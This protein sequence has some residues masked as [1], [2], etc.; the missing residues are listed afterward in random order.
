MDWEKLGSLTVNFLVE[1]AISSGI[2]LGFFCCFLIAALL[3]QLVTLSLRRRWYEVLGERSWIM[4][5]APGTVIHETGHA[6]F[7]LLFRHRILEMKLFAP[8]PE[9]TMGMVS[10]SWDPKS[11]Y[12]RA[13]NFFIGTGPIITGVSAIVL[14]TYFLM[15]EIWEQLDSHEFYTLSDLGAAFAALICRMIRTFCSAEIWSKWQT[16][17]WLISTLLIGSHVT[18]SREDLKNAV[19][20]IW[21]IPVSVLLFNFAVIWYRNPGELLLE[22]GSGHLVC[23]L[24]ILFFIILIL[25]TFDLLLHLP[26]FQRGTPE[27]KSARRRNAGR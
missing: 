25:G 8:T 16:W 14:L 20:G 12:Q 5:A 10:H 23:T 18:L 22:H 26:V 27:K 19:S 4:L 21:L 3:L 9:G 13:G 7:C 11:F 1:A 15:P 6:F 17:L 2:I 24:S